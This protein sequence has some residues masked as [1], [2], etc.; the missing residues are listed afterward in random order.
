MP[1]YAIESRRQPMTATGIVNAVMEWEE[2][3]DGK[4]RPS[5]TTPQRDESTGM[6]LHDV[7]VF[8]THAHFG[9]EYTVTGNVRV[10]APDKPEPAPLT[11]ISFTGLSV[12]VQVNKNT[13]GFSEH[14]TAEAIAEPPGASKASGS[15]S[16]SS[17][18]SSSSKSSGSSSDSAA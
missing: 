4:R 17:G 9:R 15:S 2:T 12:R 3:P 13:G 14:W 6:P 16:S 8:Y 5:D 1:W 18:T 10:G 11:P 7:E